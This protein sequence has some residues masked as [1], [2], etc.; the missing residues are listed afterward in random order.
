MSEKSQISMRRTWG[1]IAGMMAIAAL[2]LSCVAAVNHSLEAKL[3]RAGSFG[4][5][6]QAPIPPDQDE[7]P[8]T[9]MIT[10][11]TAGI[12]QAGNTEGGPALAKIGMQVKP[13][14]ILGNIEPMD[15]TAMPILAGVMGTVKE[16]YVE[17]QS[18]VATGQALIKIEIK[19]LNE[20]PEDSLQQ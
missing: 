12:F 16:I 8:E 7:K 17:D 14:T 1:E 3:S 9:V 2:S 10:S 6:F 20:M 11:P 13:E 4:V 19:E 15:A 18:V 5:K